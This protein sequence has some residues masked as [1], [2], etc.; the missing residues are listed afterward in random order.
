MRQ[1]GARSACSTA[2]GAC[3]AAREGCGGLRAET[4]ARSAPPRITRGGLAASEP[5]PGARAEP[6]ATPRPVTAERAQT[7]HGQGATRETKSARRPPSEFSRAAVET[8]VAGNDGAMHG[9][10]TPKPREKGQ[11]RQLRPTEAP[12]PRSGWRSSTEGGLTSTPAADDAATAIGLARAG[13]ARCAS[14]G[15]GAAASASC[16]RA[17]KAAWLAEVQA[18]PC[19]SPPPA[20]YRATWWLSEGACTL[21]GKDGCVAVASG[22]FPGSDHSN[23]H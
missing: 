12:V 2:V 4:P 15:S 3:G 19:A 22:S 18:M 23:T 14:V 13:N 16:T 6:A 21:L 10:G 11:R 9:A 17:P 5:A 20:S 8:A 1:G 7:L